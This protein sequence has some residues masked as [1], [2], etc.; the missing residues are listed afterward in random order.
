MD[1]TLHNPI[2]QTDYSSREGSHRLGDRERA[3]QHPQLSLLNFLHSSPDL[4]DI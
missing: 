2:R 4:L 3:G 1:R